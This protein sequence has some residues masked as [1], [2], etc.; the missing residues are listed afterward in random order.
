MKKLQYF[1]QIEIRETSDKGHKGISIFFQ[2]G[3][4]M[5]KKIARMLN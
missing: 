3:W 4:K 5:N 1:R 2:K